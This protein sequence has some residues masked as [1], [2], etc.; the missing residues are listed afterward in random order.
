M[1]YKLRRFFASHLAVFL[2]LGS[3]VAVLSQ[4]ASPTG[5]DPEG[6]F[7]LDSFTVTGSFITRFDRETTLP[8]TSIGSGELEG[9]GFVTPG[10][11]FSELSFTGSAEFNESSDG[12]NDARGDVTSVN[13]RGIGSGYTL[14]LLN[15]RRLAP[16]PLNQTIDATPSVLVN[17]NV[18]PAGLIDRIEIL[19][20]GASA[21]YGTDASAGVVN[22][23][24]ERDLDGQRLTFR[25]GFTEEG[26]F[27]ETLLTY[28]N[29]FK[30]NEG[31]SHVS[32][33][34]SYFDRPEIRTTERDYAAQGDKR[35]LVPEWFQGDT[36]IQNVSSSS[37]YANL[38]AA[39]GERLRIDGN[40]L[41]SS[42][43]RFHIEPPGSSGTRATLNNGFTVDDGSLPRSER[44]DTVPLRTLTSAAERTNVFVDLS[45]S[46]SDS[47]DLFAEF[48]YYKA[49]TFLA[50]APSNISSSANLVIPAD[51][52]WNPFGPV[53]FADGSANPNRLDDITIGGE[54]LPAEGIDIAII[55]WRAQDFGQRL[56]SVENE[57]ILGTIGLKG[58]YGN[59]WRWETG[60]RFNRNEANDLET[61]RLSK[62]GFIEALSRS[63]PDA[64]NLFA[65]GGV[66]DPANFQ[67][68]N[69]EVERTGETE[70]LTFDARVNNPQLFEFL[71]ESAGIA[72]G[73]E[74]RSEDYS[75]D[76]DPRIDG[77]ITFDDSVVGVSDVIG[78]SPT[79]DTSSERSVYGAFGELLLPITDQVELQAAVRFEDYDDFGSVTKPKV[80]I[81]WT[82]TEDILLRATYAEGFT[83]P[84]LSLLTEPIQ[85]FNTGIEDE[86]R[87]AWDVVRDAEGNLLDGDG[88]IVT[89]IDDAARS[90]ATDGTEPVSELRGGNQDLDPEESETY[91][92]GLAFRVPGLRG[93]TVSADYFNIQIKDIIRIDDTEDVLAL[94]AELAEAL[95]F[96]DSVSPGDAPQI[97]GSLVR[98]RPLTAAEIENARLADVFAVGQIDLVFNQ[99]QNRALREVSG[100]DFGIEYQFPESALG[101]FRFT[102]NLSRLSEYIEQAEVD[103]P[104]D[105]EILGDA[106]RAQPEF[107]ANASF[108]WSKDNWRAT[109]S[110]NYIDEV[111]DDDVDSDEDLDPTGESREWVVDSFWRLNASASYRFDE[112]WAEGTRLTLGVRNVF[113]EDPPLNP[114]E[115]YGYESNLHSNRGRYY[116][117]ELRY[118]F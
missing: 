81:S 109:L 37:I 94:E 117:A 7:M 30:F 43:G 41:S 75:D 86:Y 18:M 29:G 118:D 6:V 90:P 5:G 91:T 35:P 11:I 16:H 19:R 99:F 113:D 69:I 82:P 93:L 115:S 13:L 15:G 62:T 72:F 3:P 26:D 56:V 66:N 42:S 78:V 51:N 83:A 25:Y 64:L 49:D 70:L 20:D 63:T 85:R 76:R 21:L 67:A 80:G 107:R 57:S 65:G 28:R 23:L 74:A 40:T 44:Y 116:F 45:H 50:R 31:K 73:I 1:T 96:D 2:L 10:E 14:V 89:D 98:R 103:G 36:S 46:L 27:D 24:L 114:D 71:G 101:D 47:I 22:T 84:N 38:G 92:M 34:A 53:T 95:A 87:F 4:D 111:V 33:F 52:Y 59:N 79:P 12:P 48:G 39:S 61:G 32:F 112:G 68:A 102:G 77:T 110:G 8:V 17:S 60:L 88:E 100:W 108:R 106:D 55:N 54:P 97:D 104:I 58:L 9:D 105:D